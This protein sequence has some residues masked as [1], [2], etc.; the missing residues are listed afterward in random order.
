[1]L[2]G[3]DIRQVALATLRQRVG[4]VTQD[5]QHFQAS[6]RDN[7]TLFRSTIPDERIL[8]SLAALGLESWIDSLPNGLDTVLATDGAGLSAGEAQL[9]ALAR[10]FLKDPD[11]VNRDEASS[12]LDPVTEQ[13]LKRALDCLLQDRTSIIIAH[14][15]ST[16][17]RAD[18]IL[19]LEDGMIR[20]YGHYQ[21][22]V[23]NPNSVFAG[24][25]QTGLEEVLA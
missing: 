9:L 14:R 19:I 5:V 11:L 16:V 3:V 7:L 4:M 6:V 1:M 22:L 8:E 24:L 12:R 15:L 23:Q 20:E 21:E 25:L 18:Q 13:L 2:D 17:Q 10:I